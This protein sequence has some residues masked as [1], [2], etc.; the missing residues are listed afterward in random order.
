[1]IKCV[2][3]VKEHAAINTF[4][5]DKFY[6]GYVTEKRMDIDKMLNLFI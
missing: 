2:I 5:T 6:K 1:M 3:N 4:Y